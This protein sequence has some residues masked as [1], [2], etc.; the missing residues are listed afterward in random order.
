MVI[1]KYIE[2]YRE[3]KNKRCNVVS[4]NILPNSQH[5]PR[6]SRTDVFSY[7]LARYCVCE[8]LSSAMSNSLIHRETALVKSVVEWDLRE[9]YLTYAKAIFKIMKRTFITIFW[10]HF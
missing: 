5:L 1:L 2:V 7:F 8:A 6:A 10:K 4:T 3:K 9:D